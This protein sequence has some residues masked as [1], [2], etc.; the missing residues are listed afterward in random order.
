MYTQKYKLKSR[1]SQEPVYFISIQSPDLRHHIN[2]RGGQRG[3]IIAVHY[4]G[5]WRRPVCRRSLHTPRST[6]I[7]CTPAHV[8]RF[9]QFNDAD[10]A[11]VLTSATLSSSRRFQARGQV[12]CSRCTVRCQGWDKSSSM[13]AMAVAQARVG[14]EGG[15]VH[16]GASFAP[17]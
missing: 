17:R 7:G 3:D 12:L 11:Q 9:F 2:H 10:R 8:H 4:K 14:H 15:A 1:R 16:E 6:N 13:L 5:A